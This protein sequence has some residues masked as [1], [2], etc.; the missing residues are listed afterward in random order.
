MTP[1]EAWEKEFLIPDG[2]RGA[3]GEEST[4]CEMWALQGHSR[5]RMSVCQRFCLNLRVF[6]T[7]FTTALSSSPPGEP[8]GK[9][10]GASHLSCRELRSLPLNLAGSQR[11]SKAGNFWS[12]QDE[13]RNRCCAAPFSS[14]PFP[15]RLSSTQHARVVGFFF[16]IFFFC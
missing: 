11:L 5:A 6:A 16:I 2:H 13:S 10:S 8:W 7:D 9:Y 1:R 12:L 4:L 3:R 14:L 15:A